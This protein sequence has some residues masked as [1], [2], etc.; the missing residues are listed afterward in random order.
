MLQE[1]VHAIGCG[2]VVE[3]VSGYDNPEVLSGGGREMAGY[4]DG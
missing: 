3:R 2:F 1:E 4:H